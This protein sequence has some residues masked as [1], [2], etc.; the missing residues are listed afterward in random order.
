MQA[1]DK[2]EE[3]PKAHNAKRSR[4]L[5]QR[6]EE[7]PAEE[8]RAKAASHKASAAENYT[9]KASAPL[10]LRCRK[11]YV[12]FYQYMPILQKQRLRE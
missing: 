9:V 3:Q 2:R 1:T 11:T 8:R 5:M 12:K 7:S 4:T 6:D 10:R